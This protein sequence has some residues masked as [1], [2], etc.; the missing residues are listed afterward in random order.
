[1]FTGV[2]GELRP[3]GDF[4]YLLK[5]QVN[6]PL[7]IMVRQTANESGGPVRLPFSKVFRQGFTSCLTRAMQLKDLKIGYH[8]GLV[9]SMVEPQGLPYFSCRKYTNSQSGKMVDKK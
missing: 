8:T 5:Y 4:A 3:G 7:P 2:G 9:V 1:L 6:G